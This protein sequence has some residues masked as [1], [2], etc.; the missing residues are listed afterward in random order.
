[1][2]F[3]NF[4]LRQVVKKVKLDMNPVSIAMFNSGKFF[5][6]VNETDFRAIDTFNEENVL[7]V[8]TSHEEITQLKKRGHTLEQHSRTF[9]NMQVV[10][11][12]KNSETVSA[13]SDP[14][15]GGEAS[16]K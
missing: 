3:R 1:M 5:I 9:G 13:S 8:K 7:L 16:V 15:R 4:E 10:I 12:D 14:R 6:V 2:F 11:V